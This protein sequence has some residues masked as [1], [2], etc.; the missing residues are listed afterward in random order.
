[1]EIDIT[2]PLSTTSM[3]VKKKKVKIKIQAGD[4]YE[5][6]DDSNFLYLRVTARMKIDRDWFVYYNMLGK[7]MT[8]V[9]GYCLEK[10]F[11]ESMESWHMTKCGDFDILNKDE[12]FAKLLLLGL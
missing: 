3:G 5:F 11:K 12:D 6:D 10:E 2:K 1:M 7:D 9:S 4:I 8:A